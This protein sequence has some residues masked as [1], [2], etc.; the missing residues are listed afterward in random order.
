MQNSSEQLAKNKSG[1]ASQSQHNASQGMKKMEDELSQMQANMEM[2]QDEANTDA[3]RAILNNLVQLSFGQEDL[4][5]RLNANGKI[6]DIAKTQKELQDNAGTI[7][8]SL[9]KLS[10]KTMQIEGIV[11]Q[12][13]SKINYNMKQAIGDM[14]QHRGPEAAS[15]QQFSMTSINNLALM[16]SEVLEQMQNSEKQSDKH[17]PGAGSCKK[18]G[19]RGHKN[20][21]ADM[22][23]MQEQ[24]SKQLDRM[25]KAIQGKNPVIKTRAVPMKTAKAWT[26]NW[27][28]LQPSSNIYVSR[29][30]RQRMKCHKIKK[31]AAN[32]ARLLNK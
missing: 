19:G 12:E 17:T 18:P 30:R 3:L 27:Q 14:E 2:E 15:R 23:Q 1:K 11:N 24:L 29:C 16:L 31:V 32:L 26:S 7:A 20:S 5:N 28:S 6:S 8:D 25:N 10:K 22:R 9:Y 4:M 13:M 21:M